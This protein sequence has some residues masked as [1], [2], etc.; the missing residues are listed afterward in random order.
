[1]IRTRFDWQQAG[2]QLSWRDVAAAG[3]RIGVEETVARQRD[4]RE[5]AVVEGAFEDVDIGRVSVE[6]RHAVAPEHGRDR[7][8]GFA[9]GGVVG[10]VIGIA[11]SL[12]VILRRGGA[13]GDVE[14]PPDDVLPEPVERA[15]VF[16][17]VAQGGDV[18]HGGVG[19]AGPDGMPDRVFR[20]DQRHPVLVVVGRAWFRVPH[21]FLPPW[22]CPRWSR[23]NLQRSR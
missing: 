9:V 13:A 2:F 21:P 15:P 3:Q 5:H 22:T 19:V 6:Q 10:Q 4:A 18:G 20:L 14:L 23:K 12:V 8:A 17:V 16:A 7:A 1:M 11:E